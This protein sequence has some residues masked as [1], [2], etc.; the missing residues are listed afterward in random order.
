MIREIDAHQKW[1]RFFGFCLNMAFTANLPIVLSMA[2]SNVAGFTKKTTANSMVKLVS[3]Y[4]RIRSEAD[5]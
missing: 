5:I 2:S 3:E 1:T 4:L